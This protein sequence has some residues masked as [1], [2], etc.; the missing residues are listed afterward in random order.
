MRSRGPHSDS[1][2]APALLLTHG[3]QLELCAERLPALHRET[4][5]TSEATSVP[6]KDLRTNAQPNP[7]H[8][9]NNNKERMQRT[10]SGQL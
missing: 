7:N 3:N 5:S 9:N 4:S 1:G 10:G 6:V 8:K 2:T